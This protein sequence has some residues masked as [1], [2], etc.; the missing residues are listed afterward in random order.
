MTRL[1]GLMLLLLISHSHGASTIETFD[2][3][4]PELRD[5]YQGLVEEIR[6]PKCQNTNLSGSDA[7]IAKDL[8]AT[9]YRLLVEEG[10]SD[11]EI[12]SFLVARYGDFVLYKPP[13]RSDT[14]L[15]WFAPLIALGVGVVI[16]V[17]VL[18]RK[19]MAGL[20]E[21]EKARLEALVEEQKR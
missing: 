6:C 15:L 12:R 14:L 2:F 5:R 3:A 16:L 11:A 21:D 9:I 10:M 18:R 19:P 13:F 4:D 7:P 20:S 8:R 17:S 1:V